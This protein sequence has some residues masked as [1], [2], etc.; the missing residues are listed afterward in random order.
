[1]QVHVVHSDV[2]GNDW[3]A[4]FSCAQQYVQQVQGTCP[5][6]HVTY[7]GIGASM[8]RRNHPSCSLDIG[9]SFSTLHW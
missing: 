8:Y 5:E 4:L 7:A 6:L 9:F 1:M 2:T 3:S